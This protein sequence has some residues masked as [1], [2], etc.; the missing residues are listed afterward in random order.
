M[1]QN[2]R[3]FLFPNTS[4]SGNDPLSYSGIEYLPALSEAFHCSHS[5]RAGGRPEFQIPACP[6]SSGSQPEVGGCAR[7]RIASNGRS[8]QCRAR[9]A[10]ETGNSDGLTVS[11]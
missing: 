7:I 11:F 9:N 3:T 6:G 8:P 1:G 10:D 5:K 4:K 2:F